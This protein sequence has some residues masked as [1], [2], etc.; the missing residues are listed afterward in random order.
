MKKTVSNMLENKSCDAHLMELTTYGNYNIDD[1][2]D[3][4]IYIAKTDMHFV[5]SLTR[6][7]L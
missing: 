6:V 2:A 5:A 1:G 4:V 3:F 7:F